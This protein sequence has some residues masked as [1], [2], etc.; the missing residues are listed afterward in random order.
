[1]RGS[2]PVTHAANLTADAC[3]TMAEH[4][5]PQQ[6]AGMV[7]AQVTGLVANPTPSHCKA[8]P[9]TLKATSL[10][11]GLPSFRAGPG[12]AL[13]WLLWTHVGRPMAKFIMERFGDLK[14]LELK[15]M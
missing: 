12:C 7:R 4:E 9:F 3:A 1:M 8:A 6:S 14:L 10:S 11:V 13:E 15:T 2:V 5:P